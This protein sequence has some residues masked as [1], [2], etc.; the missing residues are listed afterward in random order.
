VSLQDRVLTI[1]FDHL[2]SAQSSFELRTPWAVKDAQGAD[3]AITAP[4]VYRFTVNAT[5]QDGSHEYERS[6]VVVRFA[7]IE[8]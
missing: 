3:F 8:D 6:K 5:A 4:S 1:E 7:A 2:V